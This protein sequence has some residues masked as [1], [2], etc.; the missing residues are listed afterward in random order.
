ML[1][2]YKSETPVVK[3]WMEFHPNGCDSDSENNPENGMGFDLDL[4]LSRLDYC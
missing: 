2:Y 1:G 3:N 4:K